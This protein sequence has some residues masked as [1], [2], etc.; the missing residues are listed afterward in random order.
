MTEVATPSFTDYM[1]GELIPAIQK[2]FS[3]R[4]ISDLTLEYKDLKLQGRWR[5]NQRQFLLF[6]AKE[7]VN[8]Q[9]AFACSDGQAQP[10]TIEPFLGDERKVDTNLIVF[11]LMQR[12][13]AQK[14]LLPN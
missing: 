11:G 2:A 8:G 5:N 9:K 3:D 13:N 14:W 12:L 7:D 1:T 6:F 10:Q 4:G